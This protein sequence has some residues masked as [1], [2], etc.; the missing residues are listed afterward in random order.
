MSVFMRNIV[1]NLVTTDSKD[2][3]FAE[4]LNGN[5][6]D[7]LKKPLFEETNVK[8]TDKKNQAKITSTN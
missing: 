3:F 6:R 4:K 2:H 7:L 1:E 5:S 8:W